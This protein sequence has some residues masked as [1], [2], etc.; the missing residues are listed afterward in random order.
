MRSLQSRLGLGLLLSLLV[1]FLILWL[2]VSSAIR[3]VAQEYIA[4]RL[5]HD[6]E[7]LL[8]NLSF[9]ANGSPVI[10]IARID[11][12]YQRPFSGHYYL[13]RNSAAELRSRSLWDDQLV[14]PTQASGESTRLH[15]QG[16]Q[17]QP[18]LVV[19]SGYTKQAKALTIVVAEDLS[20]VEADIE[21]FQLRFGITAL[22]MLLLLG[23][24]NVIMVR[25]GLRPLKQLRDEVRDLEHGQ[26][27]ALS[28]T[29][30]SE[31]APLVSE[32]NHLLQ[33]LNIRLRRSRHALGDL[34]HA[35][36]KPLTVLRQLE[37]EPAVIAEPELQQTLTRQV[38]S[39]QQLIEHVLRRARLAGEGHAGTLFDANTDLPVLL[40]ALQKMHRH[41]NLHINTEIQAGAPIFADR[42]DILELLGNVLDNACKWAKHQVRLQLQHAEQWR[43][44]IEDDGPGIDA[45]RISELSQ[46]GKRLDEAVEGHGLGLAIVR[47][48][49]EQYHG[50]IEFSRSPALGGLKVEVGLPL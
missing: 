36:K 17:Q 15:L 38:D 43:V 39:M 49:V 6:S 31:V 3:N 13:I 1:V 42:E 24:A 26:R 11:A 45:V 18:L 12:I 9:E 8:A 10:D 25:R 41:K 40:D 33:M 32:I 50:S 35:I 47:D 19:A 4:T 48:I 22:V 30:P 29:V 16:P 2:I 5:E 34:A 14:V 44:T 27:Q 37:R 46:R 20:A 23:L 28:D 7:T 21:A